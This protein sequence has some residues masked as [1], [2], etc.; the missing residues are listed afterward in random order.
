MRE[1]FT[2]RK[3]QKWKS[4]NKLLEEKCEI[5]KSNY[6]TNIVSDLKSSDPGQW[7]SKLKRMSSHE[8][9]K[10]ESLNVEEIMHL[11]AKEQANMIAKKI[12]S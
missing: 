7:Y 5:A 10:G 8:Q 4:L 6:Y 1:F 3:S 11:T 12:S 2:R 9:G